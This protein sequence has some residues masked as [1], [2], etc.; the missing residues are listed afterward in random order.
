MKYW[1]LGN[2]ATHFLNKITKLLWQPEVDCT[3]LCQK[4]KER[5]KCN[6][7]WRFLGC[8]RARR[9]KDILYIFRLQIL[10]VS[11]N[12]NDNGYL[13]LGWPSHLHQYHFADCSA[14]LTRMC[15]LKLLKKNSI[16]T[17]RSD[18]DSLLILSSSYL[19]LV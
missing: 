5:E 12:R 4:K 1:S 18:I 15:K 17:G 6:L 3:G 19:R 8:K 7:C 11:N 10:L 13:L 14:P 16:T 2:L 9:T